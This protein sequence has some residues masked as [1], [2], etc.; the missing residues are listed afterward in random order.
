M[1]VLIDVT[2][3]VGEHYIPGA[4]LPGDGQ[5]CWVARVPCVGERIQICQGADLAVV[6]VCQYVDVLRPDQ[7]VANVSGFL[8]PWKEQ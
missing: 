3:R 4:P 2:I 8:R 1:S 7:P 5:R 6:E